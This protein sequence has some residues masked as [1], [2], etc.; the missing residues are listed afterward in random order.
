[1]ADLDES[2]A[3][4]GD[5]P[6]AS[7]PSAELRRSRLILLAVA[8]VL[9]Y[10]TD[11]VT[12]VIAVDKLAHRTRPVNIISSV[13]DLELVRN[14]GAAFG[15]GVGMTI[16]FSIVSLAVI[17]AIVHYAAR[18]GSAW[19]ALVFGLVL[20]GALGNLTDRIFRDPGFGR[21]HVVD[22]LHIHHWPV[23]NIAD[24]AFCVAGGI[25]VLL[26]INNVPLEGRGRS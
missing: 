20:G 4:V 14:P 24:S 6:R 23:F 9:I 12:K 3:P 17:G 21:G 10:A 5:T 18:L 15:L 7:R 13:F 16:V 26:A 22:F 11:V 8:A 1:V 25:V 19:W 2:T